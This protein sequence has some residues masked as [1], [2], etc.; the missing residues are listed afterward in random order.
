M[1]QSAAMMPS[2]RQ[3]QPEANEFPGLPNTWRQKLAKI[4]RI[5]ISHMWPRPPSSKSSP[6][7]SKQRA[8]SAVTA[9]YL[10]KC[11]LPISL[12][13]T[14]ICNRSRARL[15]DAVAEIARFQRGTQF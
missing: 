1:F 4:S 14:S 10:R 5:F 3:L 9:Y 7:S 15:V 8:K 2:S 11:I 13:I 6:R 12:E